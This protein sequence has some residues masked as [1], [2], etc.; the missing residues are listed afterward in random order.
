MSGNHSR[1]YS[2]LQLVLWPGLLSTLCKYYYEFN[3][4]YFVL[5]LNYV[6]MWHRRSHWTQCLQQTLLNWHYYSKPW[7]RLFTP[8]TIKDTIK[9]TVSVISSDLPFRFTTEPFKPSTSRIREKAL[10]IYVRNRVIYELSVFEREVTWSYAYSPFNRV[11]N[12]VRGKQ[13]LKE[14]RNL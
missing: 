8:Y 5:F 7:L 11:F 12:S 3:I 2:K 10:F 1:S 4:F 13:T 6:W 14:I 9:G